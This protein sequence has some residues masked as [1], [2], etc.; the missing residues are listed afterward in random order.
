MAGFAG[1]YGTNSLQQVEHIMKNSSPLYVKPLGKIDFYNDIVQQLDEIGDGGVVLLKHKE[2]CDIRDNIATVNEVCKV[3][4]MIWQGTG[5]KLSNNKYIHL[6][7]VDMIYD[8]YRGYTNEVKKGAIRTEKKRSNP[9]RK[10]WV[11]KVHDE[12]PK[13]ANYKPTKDEG[14]WYATL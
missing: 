11:P 4:E 10:P 12:K 5:V 3:K 7:D 8:M 13:K 2:L 9:L 14:F 6:F 1:L